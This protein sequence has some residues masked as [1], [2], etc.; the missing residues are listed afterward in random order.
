[1]KIELN[2]NE[3][4]TLRVGSGPGVDYLTIR[5]SVPDLFDLNGRTYFYP[6]PPRKKMRPLFRTRRLLRRSRKPCHADAPNGE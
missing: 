5:T 2:D 3:C 6:K 1:M 4:K